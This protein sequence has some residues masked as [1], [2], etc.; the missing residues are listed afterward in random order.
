MASFAT[1]SVC[2]TSLDF[3]FEDAFRPEKAGFALAFTLELKPQ[4][5]RSI[6]TSRVDGKGPSYDLSYIFVD[7]RQNFHIYL[8]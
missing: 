7:T 5:G 4:N 6:I 8:Q 2:P 1:R 3:S